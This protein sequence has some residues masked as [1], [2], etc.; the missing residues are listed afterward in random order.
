[1]VRIRYTTNNEGT[2]L[3]SKPVESANGVF[4]SQIVRIET[5]W[6]SKIVRLTSEDESSASWSE[7]EGTSVTTKNLAVAKAKA[8]Q[9]LKYLGV[10]FL[11]EVRRRSTENVV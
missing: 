11:D 5:G 9:N 1:M 8:K 3:L 7:V 2:E 10:H 6:N 4:R